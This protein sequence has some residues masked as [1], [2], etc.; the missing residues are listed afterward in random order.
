MLPQ[1]EHRQPLQS[2]ELGKEIIVTLNA[3]Y[4]LSTLLSTLCAL[5]HLTL[6]TTL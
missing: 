6:T 2:S 3:Y 1:K 4:L 5:I